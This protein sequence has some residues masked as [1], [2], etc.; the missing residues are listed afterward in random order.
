MGHIFPFE[1]I[2]EEKNMKNSFRKILCCILALVLIPGMTT[3]SSF[4]ADDDEEIELTIIVDFS[5]KDTTTTDYDNPGSFPAYFYDGTPKSPKVTIYDGDYKLVE[6]TDYKLRYTLWNREGAPTTEDVPVGVWWN[7]DCFNRYEVSAVGRGDYDDVTMSFPERAFFYIIKAPTYFIVFHKNDGSN[8]YVSVT[9]IRHGS[10]L[11]EDDI[12]VFT[13]DNYDFGGWYTDPACTDGKE[14]DVTQPIKNPPPDVYAKWI[15]NLPPVEP[16]PI[17]SVTITLPDVNAG[18]GYVIDSDGI[19]R[20][21]P[22]V[23]TPEDALYEALYSYYVVA[24]DTQLLG[25]GL[26]KEDA[27]FKKGDEVY[28]ATELFPD[29]YELH[30]FLEEALGEDHKVAITVNGGELVKSYLYTYYED[31]SQEV[32]AR[33][34][35]VITK[36]VVNGDDEPGGDEPGGDPSGEPDPAPSTGDMTMLFIAAA[37]ITIVLAAVLVNADSKRKRYY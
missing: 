24:D 36:V 25:Y 29:D 18:D 22:E 11:S 12:P 6:G 14:F 10:I 5:N 31:D 13:R 17:T 9:G 21:H 8:D 26:P 3:V 4:A 28:I 16:E 1:Y 2:S 23:T 7:G 37:S 27:T 20:P 19:P 32:A 33:S 35:V 15:S 30:P 34:L